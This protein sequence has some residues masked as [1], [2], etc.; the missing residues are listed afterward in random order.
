MTNDTELQALYAEH[1]AAYMNM[2]DVRSKTRG[3]TRA[4][5]KA[6]DAWEAAY[7]ALVKHPGY[8]RAEVTRI[9]REGAMSEKRKVRR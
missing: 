9:L 6:Q 5:Q 8:S 2:L 4:V 3:G 7:D 1:Q